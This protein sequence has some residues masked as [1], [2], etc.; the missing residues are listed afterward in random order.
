MGEKFYHVLGFCAR[1]AMA[2]KGFVCSRFPK[3]GTLC[4][5]RSNAHIAGRPKHG[6][7]KALNKALC[8]RG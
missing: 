2:E 7:D 8:S 3:D 5:G 6:I 4:L 1:E